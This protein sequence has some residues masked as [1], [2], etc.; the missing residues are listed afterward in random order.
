LS[1]K[2]PLAQSNDYI[3]RLYEEHRD[4]F[5]TEGR[6]P[7]KVAIFTDLHLD[8]DYTPGMNTECGRPLCCRSDS[9]I[10]T[11]PKKAAGKWGDEKCDIPERTLKSLLHYIDDVIKPDVALWGGDSIPHN[12]DTLNFDTN[13]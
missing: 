6:E 11:D 1:T 5:N 12:I 10:A 3:N 8:Y 4:K 2:P 13:V 9:G 7:I